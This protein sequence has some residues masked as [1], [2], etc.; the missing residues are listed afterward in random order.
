MNRH[1]LK[2][3]VLA[4]TCVGAGL[5]ALVLAATSDVPM[6]GGY[7]LDS[8]A[9]FDMFPQTHHVETVARLSPAGGDESP[10]VAIIVPAR[11]E[12]DHIA[13]CL[14]RL[15]VAERNIASAQKILDAMNKGTRVGEIVDFSCYLQLG[16]HGEKHRACGQKC[17]NNGQPIGLLTTAH[18]PKGRPTIYD[19]LPPDLPRPSAEAVI[20]RQRM[21]GYGNYD[22]AIGTLEKM[23]TG[24]E[25]I[26]ADH[27]TAA[28]LFVGANVNFMLAFNLLEPKPVFIDYARRMTDRDAYRRAFELDPKDLRGAFATHL[29]EII[30]GFLPDLLSRQQTKELVDRVGRRFADGV[31]FVQLSLPVNVRAAVLALRRWSFDRWVVVVPSVQPNGSESSPLAPF[32]VHYLHGTDRELP[33]FARMTDDVAE[34]VGPGD[35]GGDHG[36]AQRGAFIGAGE[37]GHRHFAAQPVRLELLA[38]EDLGEQRARHRQRLGE[39]AGHLGHAR[40]HEYAGL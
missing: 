24:R 32:G 22:L 33:G 11:N 4:C 19:K 10:S 23:L 39:D 31:A 7:A 30:R 6:A 26:A 38:A 18:D 15:R 21:F 37:V 5:V 34:I 25:Y 29:S 1:A 12:A 28:D 14:D 27:F 35:A 17:V 20:Q 3:L 36:E 16:K 40:L 8:L 13:D 9:A 2:L